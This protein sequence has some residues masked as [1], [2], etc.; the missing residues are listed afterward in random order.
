MVTQA[1]LDL[2]KLHKNEYITPRKP[3]LV[4]TLPALYLSISGQGTPGGPVFS[5]KIGALYSVAFT[6]KMTRKFSGQ[7]DYAV[8]KLECQWFFEDAQGPSQLPSEQ[9][10]WKL[11]IRTPEFIT[12]EELGKAVTTLLA[13]DKPV[14]VK[15]VKLEPISEGLCVQML[16]V[17]PYDQECE[18]TRLM[19]S[20]AET[21]GLHFS[22]PH[23]EVYLSDPRR[24]PPERLKTILRHPVANG[25]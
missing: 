25:H 11:L 14:E 3:A 22:G 17:G 7:Q 9:W 16:H 19:Q 13:K 18:S 15:E 12:Q 1:K 5:A 20:F 6:I 2:Y 23:H 8:G 24:V 4:T 10:R 21:K